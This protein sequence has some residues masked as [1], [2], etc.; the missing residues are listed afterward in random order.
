MIMPALKLLLPG[1]NTMMH[2]GVIGL[3]LGGRQCGK[4]QKLRTME[5]FEMLTLE[6][7]ETRVHIPHL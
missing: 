5:S 2:S 4:V 7:R 3:Q 1:A 6:V